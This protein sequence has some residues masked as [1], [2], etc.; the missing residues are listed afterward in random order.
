M[1]FYVL[2]DL[3]FIPCLETKFKAQVLQQVV[4]QITGDSFIVTTF[5][6]NSIGLIQ[7]RAMFKA[8]PLIQNPLVESP[9]RVKYPNWKLCCL[10]A[11]K[12]LIFPTAWLLVIKVVIDKI[13]MGF[14]RMHKVKRQP[15]YKGRT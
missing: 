12:N 1:S 4:N 15:T 7:L 9:P 2:N 13:T 14:Q 3:S 11:W 6:Q 5:S 8:Y 10:L